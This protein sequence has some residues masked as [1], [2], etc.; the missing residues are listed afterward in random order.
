RHEMRHPRDGTLRLWRV[1]EQTLPVPQPLT[2]ADLT[3]DKLLTNRSL[4]ASQPPRR[5]FSPLRAYYP[6][7]NISWRFFPDEDLYSLHASG[8]TVANGQWLLI[9]PG[10][11][12]SNQPVEGLKSL[13]GS[14]DRFGIRDI[15]ILLRT[16]AFAGQ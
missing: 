2:A 1:T 9:I 12:L 3:R 7:P 14:S 13:I 5:R 10:E 6:E 16:Y 11:R 15:N 4:E 8:R